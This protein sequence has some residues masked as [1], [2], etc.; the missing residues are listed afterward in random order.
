MMKIAATPVAQTGLDVASASFAGQHVIFEPGAVLVDGD[1]YYVKTSAAGAIRSGSYT[2]ANMAAAID[3]SATARF[4]SATDAART[5]SIVYNSL[6]E[7]ACM[8]ITG[9][10]PDVT[11]YWNTRVGL[12][13]G[14]NNVVSRAGITGSGFTAGAT[15]C[16]GASPT[17]T[18]SAA[19]VTVQIL[20]ATQYKTKLHLSLFTG[21]SGDQFRIGEDSFESTVATKVNNLN[22]TYTMTGVCSFKYDAPVASNL[23]RVYLP[24]GAL[25]TS[26]GP[27]QFE[28]TI[29]AMAVKDTLGNTVSSTAT[30]KFNH[31]VPG[32]TLDASACNP[33]DARNM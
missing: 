14:A 4:K 10:I 12:V 11:L 3:T 26:A 25:S 17:C 9:N 18:A 5:T 33:S 30:F 20:T 1:S 27:K 23:V 29:P 13:S 8:P 21:Y 6:S 22:Y 19:S 28:L 24:G 32:P 16:T 31:E 15:A 2:G 7:Y